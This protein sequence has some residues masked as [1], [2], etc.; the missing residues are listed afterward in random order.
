MSSLRSASLRSFLMAYATPP[1]FGLK[2]VMVSF[3]S[4]KDPLMKPTIC[5]KTWP[6]ITIGIG[7]TQ[8]TTKVR[9]AI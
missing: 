4:T 7:P 2:E 9:G 8:G 3:L 1:E 6:N 5:W